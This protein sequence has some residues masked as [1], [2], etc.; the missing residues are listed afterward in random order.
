VELSDRERQ[1]VLLALHELM[2]ARDRFAFD[3]GS[4]VLPLLRVGATE[5]DNLVVRF[6][7]DPTASWFGASLPD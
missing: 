5:I 4:N 7:G 2:V 1:I 6:A 3:D